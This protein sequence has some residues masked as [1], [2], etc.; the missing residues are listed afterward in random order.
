[1]K[2]QGE[3]VIREVAGETVAIPVGQTALALNGMILLNPVSR[4]LWEQLQQETDLQTLVKAITD[5]F[6]ATPEE[7]R[8]DIE[9][10]LE[11]LKKAKLLAE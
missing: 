5:Q 11:N 2:L 1:M 8:A 7:A 4:V 3:F 10:F 9:D 6:D